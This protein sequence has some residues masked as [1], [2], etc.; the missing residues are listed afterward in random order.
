MLVNNVSTEMALW[1]GSLLQ[2]GVSMVEISEKMK[3]SGKI[4]CQIIYPERTKKKTI[5][6]S[7]STGYGTALK[8]KEMFTKIDRLTCLFSGR[9]QDLA[10]FLL[11]LSD[12]LLQAFILR[13]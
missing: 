11:S 1:G 3:E 7:C 12:F 9:K 13:S 2:Q 10:D 8:L 6:I 4:H 5:I